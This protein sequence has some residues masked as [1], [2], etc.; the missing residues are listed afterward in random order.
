MFEVQEVR[1]DDLRTTRLVRGDL[2]A[3]APGEVLVRIRKFGLTANNITYGT[4][5]DRAGYW[6]IFPPE[7][8]GWGRL[9][10]WG[11]GEVVA[12]AHE[13]V[14][15]GRQ[16]FGFLPMGTHLVLTPTRVSGR[17]L[18]DGSAHRRK[19]S[20]SYN[21][22]RWLDTDPLYRPD[23]EDEL[24]L[25]L[26]VFMLSFLLDAYLAER[27][28]F[29]AE[30]VVVSSA[31]SKASLGLIHLLAGRG[32]DVTALTSARNLSFVE[33]VDAGVRTVSY[34]R[35]AELPRKPTVFVDVAGDA[36]IRR[37][38]HEHLGEH[39]THSALVGATHGSTSPTAE[40]LPGP[41]QAW[42]F[43]PDQLGARVAAWGPAEFDR[44]FGEALWHFASWTREWLNITRSVGA[45]A[46]EA[47][48]RSVLDGT[49][50]P[51]VAHVLSPA[52]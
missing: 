11:F 39:L 35:I 10:V 12:S 24:L 18:L 22:Y 49:V 30:T 47:A 14:V 34:D 1:R 29:G 2:P 17:G 37:A 15:E 20:P 45:T 25:F 50:P 51:T 40:H 27:R 13:E 23:H 21:Y 44:R 41:D 8:P 19:L 46:V 52:P 4:L 6:A 5:G 26:P 9:P 43:A 33:G 7:E 3:L 32:V 28:L 42:F 38:V 31:S 16:L 36:G 48:Y